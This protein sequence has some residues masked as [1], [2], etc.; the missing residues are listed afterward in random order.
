[1]PIEGKAK[2]TKN[3]QNMFD[4]FLKCSLKAK[5]NQEKCLFGFLNAFSK[6]E[7]TKCVYLVC[8]TQAQNKAT[9]KAVCFT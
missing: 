4:K 8:H 2:P 7:P 1:M 6:Q 5:Q 3:Q 9:I